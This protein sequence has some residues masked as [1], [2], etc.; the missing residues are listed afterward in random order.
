M[1]LFS[2]IDNMIDR[3][4]RGGWMTRPFDL[5]FQSGR[6]LTITPG[7]EGGM[8]ITPGGEGGMSITPTGEGG[9]SITPG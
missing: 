1:R 6:A 3:F 8:T 5:A 9:L 7:G 4:D 2:K